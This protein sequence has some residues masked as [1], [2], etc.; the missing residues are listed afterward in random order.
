MNQNTLSHATWLICWIKKTKKTWAAGVYDEINHSFAPGFS[1]ITGQGAVMGAAQ[2]RDGNTQHPLPHLIL[3]A[4]YSQ[5]I[6]YL[7]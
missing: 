1:K 7:Y 2:R 5:G 6:L 3:C 4:H